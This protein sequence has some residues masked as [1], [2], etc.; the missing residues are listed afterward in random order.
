M[1]SQGGVLT[2]LDDRFIKGF[3][4]AGEMTADN[5]FMQAFHGSFAGIL[6]WEQLNRLWESVRTRGQAGWYIYVVGDHPPA[7]AVSAEALAQFIFELDARLRHEHD[8]D[9]CGIVY[10]DDLLMPSFVKIY[11]PHHLGA[12]CGSSAHPPLPGW[13]L[14]LI[15]PADLQAAQAASRAGLHWWKR[16][17]RA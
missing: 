12:V 17:L 10:V 1:I 3:T 11:D 2:T 5:A 7:S 4:G 16:L 8:E 6:R 14:S 15:P 9:Y 13:V